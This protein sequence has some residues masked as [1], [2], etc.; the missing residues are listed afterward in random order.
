M[1]QV[2][3]D[4]VFLTLRVQ[5]FMSPEDDEQWNTTRK[6]RQ[7]KSII[8]FISLSCLL[9]CIPCI[10][11]TNISRIAEE[12]SPAHLNKWNVCYFD[13]YKKDYVV[14]EKV[15]LLLRY[16]RIRYSWYSPPV[17]VRIVSHSLVDVDDV[18]AGRA[19]MLYVLTG[20]NAEWDKTAKKTSVGGNKVNYNF[21]VWLLK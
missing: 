11:I 1:A 16:R 8:F 19:A 9:D 15:R 6:N 17:T 18:V 14:V 10:W 2:L 4:I 5:I 7:L 20:I 21:P 13:Q 3:Q 12:N